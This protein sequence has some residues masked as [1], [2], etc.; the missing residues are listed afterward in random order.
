MQKQYFAALVQNIYIKKRLKCIFILQI[1]TY[2]WVINIPFQ[3]HL[4]H[5]IFQCTYFFFYYYHCLLLKNWLETCQWKSPWWWLKFT[6]VETAIFVHF[7][8]IK[9]WNFNCPALWCSGRLSIENNEMLSR[10]SFCV[11]FR[12]KEVRGVLVWVF[13]VRSTYAQI[14]SLFEPSL[15]TF[16]NNDFKLFIRKSNIFDTILNEVLLIINE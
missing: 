15:C 12:R 6:K 1:N 8:W 10:L 7:W 14:S 4:S 16:F 11:I 2:G 3:N 5:K 13:C 9:I